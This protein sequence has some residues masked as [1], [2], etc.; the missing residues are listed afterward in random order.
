MLRAIGSRKDLKQQT[1]YELVADLLENESVQALKQ[2]RHHIKTTRFQHSVNVSYYNYLICK[3][4]RWDA[5]SAA[6][7]GLLHDLYFYETENYDRAETNES[8]SAHHP[9]VALQ[10][11]ME[12]FTVNDVEQDIIE[13]H[14][15]PATRQM[16]HYKESYVIV[17]VDK[18]C[19]AL[20]YV[21]PSLRNVFRKVFRR[22]QAVA[23]A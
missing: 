4:F 22:K 11:A 23:S 19:A 20:E 6:R 5:V 15:W 7:A 8:H 9:H 10:N 1:Y 13:K 12:Q 2:Y 14:M 17:I 16:P 3:F 21:A 18:Y